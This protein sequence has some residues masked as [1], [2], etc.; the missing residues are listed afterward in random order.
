MTETNEQTQQTLQ[1][2]DELI[3]ELK[4]KVAGLRDGEFDAQ[5]LEARLREVT[6]LASKAAS[7]L[8]S[9]AR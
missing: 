2:L 4:S 9:V 3:G 6:E 1:Q 7:T 5:A 8:D